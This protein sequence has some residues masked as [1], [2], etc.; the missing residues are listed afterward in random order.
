MMKGMLKRGDVLIARNMQ[1][2]AMI[3]DTL[4]EGA[5]AEVYRARIG[6]KD[7]ALKWYRPE[8]LSGDQRLWE[9]LK[10][11]ISSGTPTEQFLWPFDLV[12]YP[13]STAYGGYLMPIK[14]PEFISMAGLIG[15]QTAPAFRALTMVGFNLAHS[16]LKLHAAG[17]CYRDINFGNV[18]FNPDTGDIRIA[19]NDNVDVNLKPGSIKGTPDFMAPEVA[20]DLVA[21]NAASDRFSLAVLLFRIFMIGHPLRGKR[22]L[23]LPYDPSDPDQSHR[24][25]AVD[26]VFIFDPNNDSNRPSPGVHDCPLNYWPIYPGSLRKLFIRAFTEGLDDPDA[27]VMENEWRKE[28]CALRD[29]IFLCPHCGAENFFDLELLRQKK[30]LNPCWGCLAMLGT[31]PRM[32][33]G[34]AYGSHLVTLS[35]GGQLFAHHLEGDAYN[36]K[37]PLAEVVAG[38]LGLRNLSSGTWTSRGQN[39]STQQVRFNE[40]LALASDC[41]VNFGKSEAEVRVK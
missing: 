7:Y 13:R 5:Q 19:D 14:T 15:G 8:F 27:R 23:T 38:P 17:L 24:L 33:M 16:F 39:G 22:E 28:L 35:P 36:F 40:V 2:A 26:P 9:R 32:R 34:A 1:S 4:G 21:P 18:F 12:S 37:S 10:V 41:Q 3:E 31:P 11:A 30:S 6:D 25:C 20:T 29:A